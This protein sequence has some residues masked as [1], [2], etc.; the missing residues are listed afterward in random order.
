MTPITPIDFSLLGQQRSDLS[1]VASN[2]F[3]RVQHEQLASL[4]E[5]EDEEA[6]RQAGKIE[7]KEDFIIEPE[8]ESLKQDQEQNQNQKRESDDQETEELRADD[9]VEYVKYQD[10]DLGKGFDWAG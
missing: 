10:P 5:Q 2:D 8:T 9:N 3:L 4:V 7:E 1:K 6:R